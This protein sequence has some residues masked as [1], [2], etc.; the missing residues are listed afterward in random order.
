MSYK[1]IAVVCI[2]APTKPDK[3]TCCTFIQSNLWL[4]NNSKVRN[5]G[6]CKN[7]YKFRSELRVVEGMVVRCF[8]KMCSALY[9]SALLS[10]VQFSKLEFIVVVCIAAP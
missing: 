10:M 8:T 4:G 3:W 9:I 6:L 5:I 2:A 7:H 1:S